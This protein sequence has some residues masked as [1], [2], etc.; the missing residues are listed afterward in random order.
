MGKYVAHRVESTFKVLEKFSK[1]L[2]VMHLLHRNPTPIILAAFIYHTFCLV[3]NEEHIFL[4][5]TEVFPM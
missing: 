1:G 3:H 2:F 4:H 5:P